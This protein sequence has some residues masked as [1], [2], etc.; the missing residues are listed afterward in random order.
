MLDRPVP[1]QQLSEQIVGILVA[2]ALPRRVCISKF[3]SAAAPSGP[4]SCLRAPTRRGFH[5]SEQG[6]LES[7]YER[8]DTLRRQRKQ[9]RSSTVARAI[10]K[11]TRSMI[12][13]YPV[14]ALAIVSS[15]RRIA[16]ERADSIFR[17]A[18]SPA[19]GRAR[20]RGSQPDNCWIA[21]QQPS[22]NARPYE[23]QIAAAFPDSTTR[24]NPTAIASS[25]G[26]ARRSLSQP[27]NLHEPCAGA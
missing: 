8:R 27:G 16:T 24:R 6:P 1:W 11:F 18:T 15:R 21:M 12:P 4:P 19:R 5:T 25:S 10:V 14:V 23:P 2:G 3:P 9:R 17:A 20:R 13:F 22:R 7:S 26:Q